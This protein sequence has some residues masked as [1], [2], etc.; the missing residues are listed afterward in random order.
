MLKY[1]LTFGPLMIAALLGLIWLDNRL[2][3]IDI[4]GTWMQDLFMGR[5]YLPAGLVMLG[6]FLLLITLSVGELVRMFRAKDARVDF[7]MLWLSGMI[8]CT[9]VYV[10]P[11]T[12]DS[13]TTIAIYASFMAG[14]FML[15][16]LRLAFKKTTKGALL[17]GSITMF[18]FIYIGVLPGF[19]L[20]IRRWHEAWVVA[21]II[22]II[23]SCD[24]GAFFTGCSIGKHKMIP[25]LSP[26]KTWEGLAGG[27]IFAGLVSMG[28]VALGNWTGVLGRFE[29]GREFV[30]HEYPLWF[31]F[32]VGMAFGI[33]GQAGDLTA[34]MFKRDAN[35][36]DSGSVIPG[37]GGLID[38]LDSPVL[39]APFAYWVL[40]IA[41]VFSR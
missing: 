14:L 28:M 27:V 25:W 30:T 20:A 35:I 10:I 36:K 37:F 29:G 38:V 23:K 40:V 11:Y 33:L 8:G 1:R 18:G 21:A 15:T 6:L 26:K 41:E 22:L 31:G 13:Q 24:I 12:L 34:S 17:I 2:D 7:L 16:L 19:Y 4:S 3:Q 32:V 39:V 5:A 9:L